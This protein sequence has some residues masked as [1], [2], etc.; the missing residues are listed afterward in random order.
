MAGEK[1]L[2]HGDALLKLLH[3]IFAEILVAQ[4]EQLTNL[5]HAG[6]FGHGDNHDILRPPARPFGGLGDLVAHLSIAIPYFVS[7]CHDDSH[8]NNCPSVYKNVSRRAR[9]APMEMKTTG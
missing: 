9:Q 3:T 6:I 7:S 4:F 2:G 5:I 8:P 1:L